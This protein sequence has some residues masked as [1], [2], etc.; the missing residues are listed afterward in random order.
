M[1]KTPAKGRTAKP[2][3]MLAK[4]LGQASGPPHAH[5]A[6]TQ[7]GMQSQYEEAV[8]AYNQA[9]WSQAEAGVLPTSTA[10]SRARRMNRT[11][12]AASTRCSCIRWP[13][14]TASKSP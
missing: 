7:A 8:R 2:S 10:R 13:R 6:I 11:C 3:G 9:D 5:P 4:L 12:H 1:K 14:P